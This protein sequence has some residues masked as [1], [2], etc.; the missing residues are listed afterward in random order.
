MFNPEK[1]LFF[2]RSHNQPEAVTYKRRSTLKKYAG[3]LFFSLLIGNN[4]KNDAGAQIK[5]LHRH[6]ALGVL[7]G[8]KD[9]YVVFDLI[10]SDLCKGAMGCIKCS[11]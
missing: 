7:G 4:W 11:I 1:K 10:K 9:M 3:Y 2:I 5:L 6:R 8:G